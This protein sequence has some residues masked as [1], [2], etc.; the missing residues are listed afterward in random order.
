MVIANLASIP[1]RRESLIR[2]VKSLENQV[3]RIFIALNGYTDV[4][5]EVREH[6]H[7][8]HRKNTGDA[9]KF[10]YYAK[11]PTA[12][13]TWLFCDDDLIYPPDYVAQCIIHLTKHPTAVL[14]YHG[15]RMFSRPV[16][17][18]Y[19][20]R[21]HAYRCLFD[22]NGYHDL[23]IDGT[24]GSGVM[25]FKSRTLEMNARDFKFK[26]MADIWAAKFAIEQGRKMIVCPHRADWIKYQ[27]QPVGNTIFEQHY[28]E[29][30]IQTTIYNA[31]NPNNARPN[32]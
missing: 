1:S 16:G 24:L 2:T 20:E 5:T 4:P 26:N 17:S 9:A 18:Y 27:P 12:G 8:N 11:A 13:N 28:H 15:R 14:S 23:G 19:R 21:S 29:D 22:V 6:H 7:V 30:D 31:I 32:K 3:D 10:H 25:F